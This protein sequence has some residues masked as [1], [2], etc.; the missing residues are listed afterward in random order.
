MSDAFHP[1][2]L[3]HLAFYRELAPAFKLPEKLPWEG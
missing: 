1:G 3:G 2:P